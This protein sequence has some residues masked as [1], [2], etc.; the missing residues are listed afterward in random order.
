MKTA[1]KKKSFPHSHKMRKTQTTLKYKY[2]SI[3][4]NEKHCR[5]TAKT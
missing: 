5:K 3:F 4:Q 1:R 2:K